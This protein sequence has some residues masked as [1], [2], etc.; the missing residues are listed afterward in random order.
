MALFYI[1]PEDKVKRQDIYTE[2]A[3]LDSWTIQFI[4]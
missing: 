1:D 3:K 4:Y 2:M